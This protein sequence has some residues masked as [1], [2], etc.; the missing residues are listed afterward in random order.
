MCVLAGSLE[1][2]LDQQDWVGEHRGPQLCK[3]AHHKELA[4]PSLACHL[5]PYA[6]STSV[7]LT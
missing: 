5:V 4:S 2:L 1:A 7:A 6:T 3:S